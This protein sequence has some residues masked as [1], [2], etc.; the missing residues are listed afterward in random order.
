VN[1]VM[2]L[3]VPERKDDFLTGWYSVKFARIGKSCT[4]IKDLLDIDSDAI[5]AFLDILNIKKIFRI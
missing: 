4:V 1:T 5:L 3:W 2:N